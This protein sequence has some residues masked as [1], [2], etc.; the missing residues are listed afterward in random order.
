MCCIS[1]GGVATSNAMYGRL[2]KKF[3][4][5]TGRSQTEVATSAGL[6]AY[7][8]SRIEAEKSEATVEEFVKICA[9]LKV[10]PGDVLPTSASKTT[11]PVHLR[12]T[13]DLLRQVPAEEIAHVHEA[14]QAIIAYRQRAVWL[15]AMK[16]EAKQALTEVENIF[17]QSTDVLRDNAALELLLS[18]AEPAIKKLKL[19][20]VSEVDDGSVQYMLAMSAR[21]F[22]DL[23]KQLRHT[24]DLRTG[25]AKRRHEQIWQSI[26]ENPEAF[27][28]EFAAFEAALSA[29]DEERYGISADVRA[30]GDNQAR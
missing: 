10:S 17:A 29:D 18:Q 2:L 3:R 9:A 5:D 25:A 15:E 12:K 30:N 1:P 26:V 4:E 21:Q 16:P 8:L 6:A 14:L 13:L 23:F 28:N 27:P 22:T 11:V 24:L 7:R 19:A 20:A